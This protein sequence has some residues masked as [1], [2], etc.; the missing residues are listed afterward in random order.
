VSDEAPADAGRDS[1]GAPEPQEQERR[2]DAARS[3]PGGT[4]GHPTPRLTAVGTI[5]RWLG[6]IQPTPPDDDALAAVDEL[7]PEG[8]ELGEYVARFA[9]LTALSASIAAFG[10]LADSGAVVIGAMLV[11]PLMTPIM[12]VA[13]ATVTAQNRRLVRGLAIIALG[14]FVAIAVGWL[15]G[16]V[17]AR[18]VLDVSELPSEIRSRTFPGLLD[19]GV[20]ITAG[21]AGGY[22]QPRRSAISALPGVGIAVVLVPPLATVGITAELG[23]RDEAGNA[24]LLYLTNLAAIVFSAGI[25]LLLA[26]FRPQAERGRRAL[27]T[28][29]TATVAAVALVAVPLFFHTRSVIRD[30]RLQSAVVRAV[31]EWD[32]EVRI[33]EN[34]SDQAE[35]QA[36]VELLVVG[37]GEPR[38]AWELAEI[39]RDL[40]GSPVELRL[41]YQSDELFVVSAR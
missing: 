18:S 27:R 26:G 36:H 7:V 2:H 38:P 10:L 19:L 3:E 15:V 30:R 20:A 35:D 37:R 12:G 6:S 24:F 41:R 32:D 31:E 23:L 28:R 13:A 21:A 29:L 22:I 14:T 8:P 25:A 34:N 9:A 40:Y 5:S 16:F 1:S 33:V 39:V 11:A 4:A 17:A